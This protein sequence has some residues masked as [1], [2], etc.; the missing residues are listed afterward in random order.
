[1]LEKT[2][3]Q[4]ALRARRENNAGER[5]LLLEYFRRTDVPFMSASFW[6]S[7]DLVTWQRQDPVNNPNYEETAE[8][9]QN[10]L[11][12]R[13]SVVITLPGGVSD[14]YYVRHEVDATF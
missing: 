1:M 6:I 10:P 3:P 14:H 9:G 8:A 13:V 7:S 5:Q 2:D 12:E 11:Y 4:D